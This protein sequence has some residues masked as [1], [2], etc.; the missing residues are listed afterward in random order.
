MNI[1]DNKIK[2]NPM[3]AEAWK[4]KALDLA[5]LKRFDKSIKAYDRAIELNPNDANACDA[6]GDVL[7]DKI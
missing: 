5:D 4:M 2:S 3:D 7:S 1:Q 6:K